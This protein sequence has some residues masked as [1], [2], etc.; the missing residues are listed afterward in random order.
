MRVLWSKLDP[1]PL[2]EIESETNQTGSRG[3]RILLLPELHEK[4]ESEEFPSQSRISIFPQS[5][6]WK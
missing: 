2:I 6:A 4:V 1:D 3:I 5:R